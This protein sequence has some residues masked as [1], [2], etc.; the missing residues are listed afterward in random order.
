M[1]RDD[2]EKIEVFIFL[3]SYVWRI[4]RYSYIEY[5]ILMIKFY[6]IY[7]LVYTVYIRGESSIEMNEKV[8]HIYIAYRVLSEVYL[9]FFFL[10]GIYNIKL[11]F[12]SQ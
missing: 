4:Y 7:F 9:N 8:I 3:I 5:H 11:F 2:D 1:L 10:V 12:Y 6:T